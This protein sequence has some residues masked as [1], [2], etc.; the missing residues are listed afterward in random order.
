MQLP[1]FIGYFIADVP[2]YLP[3]L[4]AMSGKNSLE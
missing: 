2:K 3:A 4:L 1:S